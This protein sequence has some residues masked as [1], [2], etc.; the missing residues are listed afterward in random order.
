MAHLAKKLA[1]C[2]RANQHP[3]DQIAHLKLVYNK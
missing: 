2:G 3:D 1:T